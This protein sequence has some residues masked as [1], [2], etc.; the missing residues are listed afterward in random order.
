MLFFDPTRKR[1]LYV[2]AFVMFSVVGAIVAA[3]ANFYFFQYQATLLTHQPTFVQT[4]VE[5]DK[6][7]ALTFDDGPD[8]E[9]TPELI[10][11]LEEE[12]VPA[13][14][15]LIGTNV[16]QYP[17]IA[18][19]LVDSGFE[20]GNHSLSHADTVHA[21]PERIREELMTTD[22]ILAETTGHSTMLYRPPFLLD[23]KYGVVDGHL[24]DNPNLRTIESLGF[25][26]VSAD[27]DATDWEKE[28]V[29]DSEDIYDILVSGVRDGR[30]VVLLHD[31]GGKGATVEAL[32]RFIPDMKKDGYTFV[33]VSYFYGLSQAD[34]MPKTTMTWL[35]FFSTKLI[36]I[37]TFGST[38]LYVF[39]SVIGI[40][41]LLRMW[42]VFSSYKL[43]VHRTPLSHAEPNCRAFEVI[44]PAYNEEANIAA[45]LHSLSMSTCLPSRVIVIDD[46]S[47]DNTAQLVRDYARTSSLEIELLQKE[48]GGT[49][50]G[51]LQYGVDRTT[52]DILVCI[53]ADTVVERRAFEFLVQ[54]FNDPAVGAVAGKM[55]PATTYTFIEKMQ[56]IEYLQGQNL[57]K[58]VLALG[59]SVGIV[60]GAIGAW[61]TAAL[62]SVGGYSTDTV[63]EDQDV[64]L[65]LLTKGWKVEYDPRALAYTETP[66]TMRSFFEQRFR[67]IY[68]TIQCF[69]K[70][71]TWLFSTQ[72]PWLGF[73]ILPNTIVFSI[74]LPLFAPLLDGIAIAGLFG[75][76]HV[77]MLVTI[78]C[79]LIV[80]ELWFAFEAVRYEK[81]PHYAWLW[82]I[83]FLRFFYQYIAA[84]AVM[85][86]L[87]M[88]FS[89]SPMHWGRLTRTGSAANVL[90]KISHS[91]EVASKE[92]LPFNTTPAPLAY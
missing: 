25:L 68:G 80:L 14:F 61:R 85:K 6:I 39:G 59:S 23:V 57:D 69:Y 38:M 84:I 30:H 42:L 45:T 20:I 21:S 72:Q 10:A 24:I 65:A 50:A 12:Q 11:L 79:L 63:V 46:G 83:V 86:S 32:R 4:P 44:I 89:G 28:S 71:D 70:Y 67:W 9:H 77:P 5:Q 87:V 54:H 64:T 27:I 16:L 78:F 56:Y 37:T 74:V 33:P 51:A 19:A 35:Q 90:H 82:C 31:R 3:G 73:V 2:G 15:F 88:A 7:I 26:I 13:T 91:H 48:N 29:N 53:D 40:V 18:R 66:S 81:E 52:E 43:I 41:G 36:T 92:Q 34:V 62:L 1:R 60:P 47:T 76:L 49:K 55:Y 8:P 75:F 58:R 17:D 22:H